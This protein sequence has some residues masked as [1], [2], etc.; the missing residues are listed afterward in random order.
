MSLSASRYR[1][2]VSLFRRKC[3]AFTI[4]VLS[5]LMF[6][7]LTSAEE[8]RPS[9]LMF[10]D[11][12]F[13][14]PDDMEALPPNIV[15]LW[16]SALQRSDATYI[17]AAASDIS[18]AH[19]MGFEEVKSAIPELRA[20]LQ[21]ENISETVQTVVALTLIELEAHE[22]ADE[23]FEV[24]QKSGSQFRLLV[25]PALA[26]WDYQPIRTVWRTRL[27]DKS[28]P[29]RELILACQGSGQ[30]LDTQAIP[31]LIKIVHSNN[32]PQDIRLAAAKAAGQI[33]TTGLETYAQKLLAA[34]KP[35]VINRLCAVDLLQRHSSVQA[36]Q[37]LV[38]LFV[39][40]VGP[41]ASAAISRLFAIDPALVI[42]LSEKAWEHPNVNIRRIAAQCLMTLPNEKRLIILANHLHDEN[43]TLRQQIRDALI[44]H[45][46]NPEFKSIILTSVTETLNS[47]DWRGQE[48]A[49]LI[50]GQLDH[51]P[52]AQ[53]FVQLLT[54]KRPEIII[55]SAWALKKVAVDSTRSA[56]LKHAQ[57]QT[58]N[59]QWKDPE[60][61][62]RQVAQLFE[63]LA[64]MN[65]REAIPL[66]Q[67][68]LPYS[69]LRPHQVLSR[70][71]AVWALGH[72]LASDQN[73]QFASQLMGRIK[74]R[75]ALPPEIDIVVQMSVISLGRIKAKSQ[76]KELKSLAGESIQPGPF[77]FSLQWAIR[78]ISGEMIPTK[79]PAPTIVRTWRLKPVVK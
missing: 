2:E 28:T 50:L 74:A 56:M 24:S 35:S 9:F 61:V 39:D 42:D 71:A 55:A 34:D 63:G 72:L 14:I 30:V 26:R 64:M 49:C 65:Y 44:E 58:D 22:A 32:R 40:P 62:D 4:S 19:K 3:T 41:V 36:Q 73:E 33:S 77:N 17:L 6:C 43:P 8:L 75:S 59:P 27:Q 18:D 66:M 60:A 76:L 5:C 54:S 23:L 52:A 57:Y 47:D 79:Q 78:E 69:L 20:V 12:A 37:L 51:E 10:S 38:Q 25:E 68:Y 29:R 16:R 11:P 7:C 67:K 15:D 70:G 21:D 46:Q 45:A 53:R 48:Q 13:S 1:D 31:S